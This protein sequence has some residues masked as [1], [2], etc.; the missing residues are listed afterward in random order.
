MVP[1]TATYD[2]YAR[3]TLKVTPSTSLITGLRFNHDVIS[4]R[5]DQLAP[6]QAYHSAGSAANNT[7]VGDIAFKQQLTSDVMSYVS[8]SRGYSPAAY[9]TSAQFDE[10]R[11]VGA[12][13]AREHR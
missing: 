1:T 3:S 8:Y 13:I 5:I 7:L 12:R 10:Q 4:Y 11:L 6:P 2:L 9:N